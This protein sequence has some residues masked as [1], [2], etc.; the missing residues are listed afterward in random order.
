MFANLWQF[1]LHLRAR[2][3]ALNGDK[4]DALVSTPLT[5]GCDLKLST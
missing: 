5:V 2:M 4:A 3:Q 1:Y